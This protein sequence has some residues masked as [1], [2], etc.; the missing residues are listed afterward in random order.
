MNCVRR[1]DVVRPKARSTTY[2]ASVPVPQG[3]RV[4]RRKRLAA[5]SGHFAAPKTR[6]R[7]RCARG[8]PA[9]AGA[10]RRL[11]AER[12]MDCS[13]SRRDRAEKRSKVSATLGCRRLRREGQREGRFAT[14]EAP[15]SHAD[16]AEEAHPGVGRPEMRSELSISLQRL[17]VLFSPIDERGEEFLALRARTAIPEHPHWRR[18]TRSPCGRTGS[19]GG[20][21]RAE[22]VRPTIRS[23]TAD[24]ATPRS[25]AKRP[26]IGWTAR[27]RRRLRSCSSFLLPLPETISTSG[28]VAGSLGRDAIARVDCEG[29]ARESTAR[30]L[31]PLSACR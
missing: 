17:P 18:S 13:A 23:P 5:R 26:G 2:T 14:A 30:V 9:A 15:P 6:P 27:R 28:E 1:G 21:A 10:R 19:G 12:S 24:C 7:S 3:L 20:S 11:C 25:T 8:G 16:V 31:S 29:T 22:G 4:A